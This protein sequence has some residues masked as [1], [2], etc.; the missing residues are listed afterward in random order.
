[1]KAAVFYGKHDVRIEDIPVRTPH[2]FDVV[3]KTAY[4]G[5]CGTDLHI[6]H[7][8]E[9]S[10]EAAPPVVLG[11][12]MS[13]TVVEVGS[14]V[15]KLAVGDH[16]SVDPN[17]SCGECHYCRCGQMHFCS[18]MNAF[19]VN[20][21][22]GF[23]EYCTLPSKVAIKAPEG[24]PLDIVAFAEPVSCCLHGI[25]LTGIR[26]GDSVLL[27]GGG[28]IGLLM[29]QLAKLSG[30]SLLTLV[31]PDSHKRA[32]AREFG[33][34]NVFSCR[35]EYDD[36]TANSPDIRADKVVECV[37]KA[38]TVSFAIQAASK[39]ATVMLFG[40][41]PPKAT[42]EIFPFEIF[43]KELTIKA[44]FVNPYTQSRAMELLGNYR[45]NV[46]KLISERVPLEKLTEV[47]NEPYYRAK[48]KI[49]VEF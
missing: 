5:V 14:S 23:A 17:F 33:A 48:M 32:I 38:E 10:A 11:H 41:T 15:T 39:G 34:D 26:A 20:F 21:H 31:E 45:I 12:E 19:G 24:L 46:S 4:C 1:M 25:D 13:G 43:K 36:F 27:I 29:L 49:L 2:D 40:L 9:G 37:G 28:T 16:V 18:G 22:G 3:V 44:S 30:A 35:E 6:Y 47:F 42:V 8:D 7:G